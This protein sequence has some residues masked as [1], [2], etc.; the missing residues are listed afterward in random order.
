[1]LTKDFNHR[2]VAASSHEML[3]DEDDVHLLNVAR[4]HCEVTPII[5]RPF[6]HAA[7][8]KLMSQ[9]WDGGSAVFDC[10]IDIDENIIAPTEIFIPAGYTVSA[11]Y[12]DDVICTWHQREQV[13]CL[14]EKSSG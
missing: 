5:C 14:K 6:V 11:V 9:T 7:Q 2:R 1:M 13:I 3:Q 8:G 10:S 4:Q 12:R